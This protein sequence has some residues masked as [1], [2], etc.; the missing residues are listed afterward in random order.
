MKFS[1]VVEQAGALLQRKGRMTY[2]ALKLEFALDEEHFEALKEELLYAHSQVTDDEGRGLMWVGQ[3]SLASSVQGLESKTLPSP[4]ARH[5]T[6]DPRPVSYTPPHLANRIRVE[7]AALEARSGTDG[8]RKTITALFADLKGSTALIEGLDPE[9][10]QAIIDPALQLMMD[11]VHQYDGYV[12][13]ALGDGIFALFGAPLAHEDH[14]QRALYA[15]LRM[16]ETM[17][18]YA[19]TLRAKGYPPLLMRVG[20]NTGEVVLRSIRKDDLHADYVPVGH[21]TNLAAR[22]EQLATPGTIVVSAYT[23]RLTDGYFAFK[24]LGPTQIKGVE[25]ALNIYEVLGVGPLRTRL[26]VSAR[27]GLTRFVGRQSELEQM[28]QALAHAKE[29]HGQIVGMMGEPGL[30]KS[31]LFYE[32]KLLSLSGCLVLEAYSVSHGKATAYLPMI[33]LLKSYFD[34][35]AGDDEGKRREKV[36]GK[37]LTLDRSLEDTLPYLFVLLSIEEQLSPLQQ[38]D[39]QIR[40]QRTFEALKKLFLRESLNQPLILIFEDLHWIDNETQGFLDTFSEGVASAK[41]LLLVN[42]RPEYRHEWGQKTYYTQLRLA[43]LG[44]AEA[45]ELLTFLLGNDASLTPVKSLILEKT[46]GTP[47]FMEEVVQTLAEEGVLSGER[48]HYQ[49]TQHAPTLHIPPTVQ[50]ILAARID[51]LASDEKALLQQL[52]VIG[53]EFPVSLLRQVITQPEDERYRLLASLQ[54][55]EFLYE[56]P[57]FPEVE[58]IFKH[59]L[60]QEVA[61]GTVLQERRKVLHEQTAQAMELL[62]ASNL[63]EHYSELA[64]HYSRSG[65]PE[66][67]IEYLQLAG[68]QA[69]QR[70][71]NVEAISHLSAA[72]ALLKTLPDTAARA[73]QE[74]VLQL[75]L[76]ASLIA[77]KGYSA[78]EVEQTYTRAQELCLQMGEPL[79]VAQ[80]LL[81]LWTFYAVRGNHTA[82]LALGEQFLTVAQRQQDSTL[83]LVVNLLFGSTLLWLG[84]FARAQAHLDQAGAFYDPE[85]HRDLAH[86]MGQDPGSMALVSEAETL[87]CRGYPD[88]AL[89]RAR[90]ALSVAQALSH[91]FSLAL[92]LGVVALVHL[93][94]REGQ[95]AQAQAEALLILAHEHGFAGW[96]G[97]GTSLQGWALVERAALSSARE[98]GEA[99]LGQ[100]QEGMAAVRATGAELWVPVFLGALAQGYAQGGQAEEGLRAIAEALAMVEKNDERWNEAELY[101]IKGD[102]TLQSKV[103]SPRSKVEEEAEECF[104]KAVEIAQR[105]QA[106]SLELRATMSL[107]RLWQSHGKTAEA[108]QMLAEIYGWFTEG[109][110]TK[111]LQEAQELLEELA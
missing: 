108:H 76:G 16:Q 93:F 89:E 44:R 92:A 19:D 61:Y 59:A 43:P 109:F 45:E 24:D 3:D 97:Y 66:K 91:P 98:Q 52:A 72:L 28:Q 26:Q 102:L 9:E 107:A 101:R 31:R 50:G 1:E 22:M 39:P 60:T 7:Q 105:Q 37:V 75:S 84:E 78:A 80:V 13:Q 56:Q 15:A 88:Q 95:D 62:Y 70:S 12:A 21:S 82:S 36:T 4:D 25:D 23:H 14:P 27:R 63:D 35:Q 106:K 18:R 103:Q 8:E 64:H 33:E 34:I 58:Y 67:A 94:R 42:Y 30:G 17:R 81:G 41:I 53:R 73:R 10:A 49:L 51:R 96:L 83:S 54:R 74:L 87:W 5:Q 40:R 48:G 68:R 86:D 104:Y 32:F 71:A 69:V 90:R 65:N 79:Q 110:D 77:T 46:E 38:M 6:L 100:L 29:G 2:R 57:A 85:H 47:F 11:A 99:G 55:K 20:I 111:D